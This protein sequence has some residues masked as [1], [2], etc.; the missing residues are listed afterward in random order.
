MKFIDKEIDIKKIIKDL[1]DTTFGG[2]NKEQGKMVSLMK[3]L[4]FSDD[5]LSNKFMKKVD[6]A[7]NIISKEVLGK[8]KKEEYKRIF[9][10]EISRIENIIVEDGDIIKVFKKTN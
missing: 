6:K 7:L 2:S 1:G 10:K 4:A 3:G 9:I 5:P 8:D